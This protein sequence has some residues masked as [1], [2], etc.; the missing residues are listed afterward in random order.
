MTTIK[1]ISERKESEYFRRVRRQFLAEVEAVQGL[2]HPEGYSFE[3]DG[4]PAEPNLMQRRIAVALRD[5]RLIG[6]WSGVGSGKTLSAVYGSRVIDA[7]LTVVVT[8]KATL[9]GWEATILN[10]FPE[11]TVVYSPDAEEAELRQL[12]ESVDR[13][14]HTYIL[15]NYERFQLESAEETA[16]QLLALGIDMLVFD[17]VQFAKQRSGQGK[18]KRREALEGLR[19]RAGAMNPDLYV[20]GMSATPVINDL[21]EAKKLLQLILG[22]NERIDELE[23]K[24]GIDTALAIH[25]QLKL[26]GFRHRPQYV[27]TKVV[28]EVEARR[29]DLYEAALEIVNAGKNR[30]PDLEK[31]FVLPKLELLK[32]KGLITPG[33]IIYCQYV[34]GVTDVA[35]DFVRDMGLCAAVYTGNESYAERKATLSAFIAGKIDVLVG[36][37]PIGTGI[38]GL[39]KRS[40]RLIFLSLPW[41]SA[42]FEQAIGRLWRTGSIFKQI[43]IIVPHIVFDHEGDEWSWD[44][45]RFGII[46]YKRTLSDCAVDGVIPVDVKLNKAALFKSSSEALKKWAKRLGYGES[47]VRVA[48]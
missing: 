26:H 38:D 31:L 46:N 4:A 8:N 30:A 1:S 41:T 12:P 13:S 43:D 23:T 37:S 9:G 48:A 34:A 29:N 45:S 24:S 15:L 40:D 33:S 19:L 32:S 16:E 7:R 14:A 21:F 25:K 22:E 42:G 47:P 11:N 18:S 10:A 20:L 5:K 27:H 44:K 2:E 6:N 35:L 36:S 17:E 39:Q 28:E 3:V